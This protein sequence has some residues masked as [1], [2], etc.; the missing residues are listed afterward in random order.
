M[1]GAASTNGEGM[2]QW[3]LD[4]DETLVVGP[5]SYALETA[6][7]TMIRDNNL[8][9][10][11]A[12]LNAALLW[13]Q[14]Q[15]ASGMGDMEIL[16][17][18]FDEMGWPHHLKPQ[19]ASDVFDHYTPALFNDTLPFL[20]RVGSIYV[21][22]NNNHAPEIAAQLGITSYIA[23]FFTPKRCG[24]SSGKPHRDLWDF[25][26]GSQNVEGALLVGDDPW[27]DGMFANTCGIDCILVDRLDRFAHLSQYRRV[28]SLGAIP[29]ILAASANDAPE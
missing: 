6:L 9:L 18:L 29:A 7:P 1:V 25:V 16:K 19:L 17:V 24:V 10:D 26:R 22:S 28:R 3:F 12:R 15:V 21:L 2:T 11:Q 13:G 23:E 20:E 14:E 8:S 5:V 4:L 27:A